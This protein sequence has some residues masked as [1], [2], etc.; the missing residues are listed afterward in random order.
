[1]E[2]GNVWVN[3]YDHFIKTN[4]DDRFCIPPNG[5][6]LLPFHL[7]VKL[8]VP[9]ASGSSYCSRVRSWILPQLLCNVRSH[10]P[11]QAQ[12]YDSM[13]STQLICFPQ[14]SNA[15]SDKLSHL[16]GERG[17]LDVTPDGTGLESV[18]PGSLCQSVTASGRSPPNLKSSLSL[19]PNS[20]AGGPPTPVCGT[21][22][23]C[24]QR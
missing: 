8:V 12:K 10:T 5:V 7:K 2:I 23:L 16:Q 21:P 4:G 20:G 9:V 19:L 6:S 17:H 13:A 1:M 24:G 11:H 14:E 18:M 15:G 22:D 3:R